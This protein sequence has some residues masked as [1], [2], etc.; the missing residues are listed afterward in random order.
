MN[1]YFTDVVKGLS[2][3]QLLKELGTNEADRRM[4]IMHR[5]VAAYPRICDL[6]SAL[7]LEL[8]LLHE[9]LQ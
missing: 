8:F 6:D 5:D 1:N 2:R 3:E 9:E 7:M 4:A